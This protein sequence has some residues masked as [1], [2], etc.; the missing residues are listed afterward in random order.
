MPNLE[1]PGSKNLTWNPISNQ[2]KVDVWWNNHFP[3]KDLESSNW[4]NHLKNGCL[5]YQAGIF[6]DGMLAA[7]FLIF[8][9]TMGV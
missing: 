6:E 2:F 3:C 5:G 1:K 7:N 9:W 8:F 4:N